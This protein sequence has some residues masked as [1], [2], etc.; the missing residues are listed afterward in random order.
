MKEYL[1]I[2]FLIA[3]PQTSW[4]NSSLVTSLTTLTPGITATC[5]GQGLT[6]LKLAY[7]SLERPSETHCFKTLNLVFLFLVE[8]VSLKGQV[9]G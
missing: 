5:Q 1:C 8:L 3:I 7:P 2:K 4:H 9:Q 6:C